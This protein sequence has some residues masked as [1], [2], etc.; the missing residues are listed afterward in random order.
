ML[1][2]FY[3]K[4][5]NLMKFYQNFAEF[6]L[7][8][9]PP[10]QEVGSQLNALACTRWAS[11]AFSSSLTRSSRSSA[12]TSECDFR[13]VQRSALCRCRRELSNAYL[14]SFAKFRF[15]RAENEPCKVYPIERCSSPAESAPGG[16]T[17]ASRR[18]AQ[19]WPPRSARR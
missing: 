1:L 19:M 9:T 11:S 17:R 13:S 3:K 8:L 2:I 7:T 14:L 6:L 4:F 12:L 16:P 18:R 5:A 15:D 10:N